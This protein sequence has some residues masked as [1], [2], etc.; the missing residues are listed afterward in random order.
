MTTR[1]GHVFGPPAASAKYARPGARRDTTALATPRV[2][3]STSHVSSFSPRPRQWSRSA[4]SPG[5]NVRGVGSA[6][7]ASVTRP[8]TVPRPAVLS[9]VRGSSSGAYS[10]GPSSGFGGAGRVSRHAR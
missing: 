6:P 2:A 10:T 7:A 3:P 4:F 9:G 1:S 8:R 5:A